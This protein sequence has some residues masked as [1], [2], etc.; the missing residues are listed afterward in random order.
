LFLDIKQTFLLQRFYSQLGQDKW[1]VGRVFPGVEDGFFVDIGAGHAEMH[2]NS[3]ALERLG[4]SGICVEPFPLAWED[5][6]CELF[7]EVVYD[8]DGEIVTFRTADLLG[9]IDEHIGSWRA[10][11]EGFPTVELRSTTIGSILERGGAPSFIHYVSIDTE[12][13]ELEILSVFPFD[14]HVVGAFS[15]EHN[16]EE[17]KRQQI[18]R[19]LESRG[20]EFSREQLVDD[21]YVRGSAAR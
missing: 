12:G 6:D 10:E 1:I 18:R 8:K 21:W 16:Y 17:P 3:K 15:V 4:W 2:S 5:R 20:Y 9:G 7:R 14:S 13:S 11:V 19:L